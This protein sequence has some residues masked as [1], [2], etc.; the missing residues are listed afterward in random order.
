MTDEEAEYVSYLLRLRRTR[1]DGSIVWQAS[2]ESTRTSKVSHFANLT[3]LLAFLAERFAA[4]GP[5]DLTDK[6][7]PLQQ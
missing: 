2:L 4:T 5:A 6:P 7:G 1:R 3:E